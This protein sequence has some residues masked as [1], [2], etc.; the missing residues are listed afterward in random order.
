[1]PQKKRNAA[2]IIPPTFEPLEGRTLLSAA[3]ATAV[4]ESSAASVYSQP[5]L[6]TAT[7]TPKAAGTLAGTVTFKSNGSPIITLPLN[8]AHQ[9]SVSAKSLAVGIDKITAIYNGSS[10]FTAS[11][12]TAVTHT[13][14]AGTTK[15]TLAALTLAP[16][17]GQFVTLTATVAPLSPSVWVPAGTVQ[18]LDGAA[19][20][21]TATL[22]SAGQATFT[23]SQLFLGTHSI[24]AA[25]VAT[26]QYKASKSAVQSLVIKK[27]VMTTL[28]GGLQ[29][30][31]VH[32]GTGLGA[33]AGQYLKMNYTGYLTNGTK[34][35]SSLNPGRT[36]FDFKLGAGQVI[37]GWD[38]GLVGIKV[39]E[40]RVLIIPPALGYGATGQGSIPPN[41]TLYFIVQLLAFNTSKLIVGGGA[42]FAVPVTNNESPLTTNGTNFGTIKVGASGA[43]TKFAIGNG[44]S[45]PLMFTAHPWVQLSGLNAADFVLTPAVVDPSGNFATFTL[46]FK[47]KAKGQR[48]AKITIPSN[49]PLNPNF[50]FQI[51]GVGA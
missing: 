41:A 24:S 38:Q 10:T 6:I 32:V 31:T 50:S 22:N 11:T 42:N 4:V 26:S 33:V 46:T 23:E 16:V 37:K 20:I 44:G 8:A 9:A 3:T 19:V 30:A 2:T 43:V 51:I 14:T 5:V 49:D 1:M 15:T 17:L 35:D 28:A 29:I 48:V 12:S 21:G 25:Y 36:P 34:F 18:F 40:Q 45:A 27:P 39:G 7:V 47:P 13:V